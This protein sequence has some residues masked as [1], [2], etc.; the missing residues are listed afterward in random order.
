MSW[1]KK[2][3]KGG[4]LQPNDKKLPKG[5]RIP[6]PIHTEL[7][8]ST[9]G[10]NG[11]PAYLIPIFKY[12][13]YLENPI[14]EFKKT[15]EHLG[16][17]FKTWQEAD[18]WEREVRHPYVEKGLSIPMD[19]LG[20]GQKYPDGGNVAPFI[21]SDINEYKKRKQAYD[22]SLSLHNKTKTI[23]NPKFYTN[24]KPSWYSFKGNRN[25]VERFMKKN[26][27]DL[28][29]EYY[30]T[31]KFPGKIQ[32]INVGDFG[33]GIA[34]PIYK[35]PVQQV[36]YKEKENLNQIPTYNNYSI[37]PKLTNKKIIPQQNYFIPQP[38][39]AP[40]YTKFPDSRL[41]GYNTSLLPSQIGYYTPEEINKLKQQGIFQEYKDGGNVKDNTFVKKP[42]INK[43][44]NSEQPGKP[45]FKVN[46][47]DPG[48]FRKYNPNDVIPVPTVKGLGLVQN[49]DLKHAEDLFNI[50]FMADMFPN[51][52]STKGL[53]NIFKKPIN[54]IESNVPP[55]V[56]SSVG[57]AIK[58]AKPPVNANPLPYYSQIPN[59]E[60]PEHLKPY[61]TG[62]LEPEYLNKEQQILQSFGLNPYNP[63]K[64]EMGG[65]ISS[66]TNSNWLDKYNDSH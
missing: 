16:G 10:E 1:L 19:F 44:L 30:R 61:L 45:W 20:W 50:A 43:N 41:I 66:R 26:N 4:F 38:S 58:R 42:I 24:N 64:K 25:E 6:E 49:S 13:K 22:D 48:S 40:V 27:V 21:T 7:A 37:N 8:S 17:P 29:Y 18:K 2:Y 3:D 9:G 63:G 54:Y 65:I 60:L 28:N 31:G 5:T 34:Y 36:L 12:G 32:P 57:P 23:E 62:S 15:G 46:I 47:E 11:E 56:E 52:F 39:G 33:E 59:K 35:K 51:N 53:K 55:P 14:E